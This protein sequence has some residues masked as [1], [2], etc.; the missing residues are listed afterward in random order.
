M[1]MSIRDDLSPDYVKN[2]LLQSADFDGD[3]ENAMSVCKNKKFN[4]KPKDKKAVKC[5]DCGGPYFRNKCPNKNKEKSEKS[6]GVLYSVLDKMD[7][8]NGEKECIKDIQTDNKNVEPENSELVWY[9]AFATK[10]QDSDVWYVD[11]GA[12]K[13]MT[14]ENLD[15]R[16]I[17]KPII[18][19]V[20]VANN[21]KMKINHVGDLKC[22]IGENL[23][24]DITL[25]E[26]HYYI[27]DLCVNLLSVS[28]I[29]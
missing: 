17:R 27:P 15:L 11:S 23:E 24:K 8:D 7:L 28:Q 20:K 4:K 1:I 2:L 9:S 12:T 29:I 16:N 21:E 19:E 26:V 13:H 3:S 14:H 18:S 25:S 5:Y 22:K 6:E 10:C